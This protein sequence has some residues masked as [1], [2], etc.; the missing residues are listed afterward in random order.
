MITYEQATGKLVDRDADVRGMGYSGHGAG[1]NNPSM[2]DIKNVGPI[3]KGYYSIGPF[4]D[5]P[6]KGPIVCHLLP[7]PGTETFG[8]SGFMI[9]GDN[10]AMN[11]TAS[12][13]CIILIR[14]V[15]EWLRDSNEN[16]LE[17]I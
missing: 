17:V 16:V 15:R 7:Q 1:V 12:E 10:H 5:D 8:R 11:H 6:E 4:F 9:H 14:P 13:G 2:Q 3:P